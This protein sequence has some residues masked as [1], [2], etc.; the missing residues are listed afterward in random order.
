MGI[1]R[2]GDHWIWVGGPVPPGSDA[3]TI[4]SVISVRREAADSV[5]LLRHEEEH[6]RQWHDLGPRRFLRQYL[7]AYVSG[8]WHGFGHRA[9]Y[10]M[11]PLE[12]EAEDAARRFTQSGGAGGGGGGGG[13][14]VS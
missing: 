4:W 14:S 3:I 5:H 1:R 2:R 9:A 12:I 10:R 13:G 11:I 8:R 6:V 7:G